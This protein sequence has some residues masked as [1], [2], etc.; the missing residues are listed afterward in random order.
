MPTPAEAL[1][2][3]TEAAD[4]AADTHLAAAVFSHDD[5]LRAAGAVTRAAQLEATLARGDAAAA[6]TSASM[7][8]LAST[9]QT[10][11]ATS[12][13]AAATRSTRSGGGSDGI[14]RC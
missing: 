6:T 4:T 2:S 12:G 10:S 1:E 8:F 5:R 13:T 11:R 3:A 9:S 7:P 14:A